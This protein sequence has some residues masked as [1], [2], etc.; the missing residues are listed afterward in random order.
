MKSSAMDISLIGSALLIVAC[1]AWLSSVQ[2]KEIMRNRLDLDRAVVDR[3]KMF[4]ETWRKI[5]ELKPQTRPG[6]KP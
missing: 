6:D 2:T 1:N 5:D 4:Q 3:D